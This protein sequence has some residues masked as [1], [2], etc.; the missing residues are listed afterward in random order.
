MVC[1][2][3]DAACPVVMG[4]K[5]RISL[6]FSDP[7]AFDGKPEEAAKYSERRDDIVRFMLSTLAIAKEQMKSK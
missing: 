4:A 3:A 6:P 7:K 2:E 5:K 1:D